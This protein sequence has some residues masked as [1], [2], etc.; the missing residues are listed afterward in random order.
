M[1]RWRAKKK[2]GG[3]GSWGEVVGILLE[4]ECQV[5]NYEGETSSSISGGVVALLIL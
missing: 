5:N 4:S 1:T 2:L 3:V